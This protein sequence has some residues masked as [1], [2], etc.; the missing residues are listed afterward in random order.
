MKDRLSDEVYTHPD[1]IKAD[2]HYAYG[3]AASLTPT[4]LRV[5]VFFAHGAQTLFEESRYADLLDARARAQLM[6]HTAI[7][8]WKKLNAD[9]QDSTQ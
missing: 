3:S 2:I 5:T 7:E 8:S 9:N 6:V 1:G 4:K